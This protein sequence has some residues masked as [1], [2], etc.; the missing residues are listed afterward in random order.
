MGAQEKKQNEFLTDYSLYLPQIEVRLVFVIPQRR[1]SENKC[2]SE[3]QQ[4]HGFPEGHPCG[5]C[6]SSIVD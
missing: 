4:G 5:A 2:C 6:V 1:Y 3:L